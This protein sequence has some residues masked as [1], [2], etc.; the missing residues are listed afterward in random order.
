MWDAVYHLLKHAH[1]YS[2]CCY[3]H[4]CRAVNECIVG[5]DTALAAFS[6][7]EQP[8]TTKKRKRTVCTPL[9]TIFVIDKIPIQFD[10][11]DEKTKSSEIDDS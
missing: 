11:N 9:R 8:K 10:S 1:L 7:S 2:F 4:C 5:V 3:C 6:T